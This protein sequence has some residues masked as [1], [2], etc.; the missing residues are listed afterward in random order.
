MNISGTDRYTSY[1]GDLSHIL[2]LINTVK[3]KH[4]VKEFLM[5]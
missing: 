5:M 3:Y 2:G 4:F 1:K